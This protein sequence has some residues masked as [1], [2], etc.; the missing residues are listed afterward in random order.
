MRHGLIQML[1]PI[2]THIKQLLDNLRYSF[3]VIHSVIV[4][5]GT[6]DSNNSC[7]AHLLQM[8]ALEILNGLF[9]IF[10]LLLVFPILVRDLVPV[11]HLAHVCPFSK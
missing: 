3:L 5:I 1:P 4:N 11:Y 9:D 8:I 10:G 7:L 2:D 6:G